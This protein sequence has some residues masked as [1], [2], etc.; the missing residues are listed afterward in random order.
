MFISDILPLS[1]LYQ[2]IKCVCIYTYVC[3]YMHTYICIYISILIQLHSKFQVMD[4][5][6]QDYLLLKFSL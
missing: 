6:W 5:T 4:R 3:I 1:F 2:T